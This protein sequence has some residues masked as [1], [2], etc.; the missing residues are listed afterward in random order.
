MLM[1]RLFYTFSLTNGALITY[2]QCAYWM[3]GCLWMRY[4]PGKPDPYQ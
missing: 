1:L 2:N 4:V 3:R